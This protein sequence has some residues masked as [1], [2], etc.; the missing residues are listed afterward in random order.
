MAK[1]QALL[2]ET[3]AT[4]RATFDVDLKHIPSLLDSDDDISDVIFC[5]I[6]LHDNRPPCIAQMEI[7]LAV[8]VGRD[9]RLARML[10]PTL[11]K[12]IQCNKIGFDNALKKVWKEYSPGQMIH[13]LSKPA[14][15]WL[16]TTTTAQGDGIPQS[17]HYNM[18]TGLLLINGKPLGRL[19]AK[20]TTHPLY[21]RTLDKV[22]KSLLCRLNYG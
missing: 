8:L 7:T 16:S 21:L 22:S 10:E 18:M 20:I 3:A 6:T 12:A 13:V 15:R 9:D 1:F 5:A 19:P 4:C 11:A 17:V 2:C 14:E